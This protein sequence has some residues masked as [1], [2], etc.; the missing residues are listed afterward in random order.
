LDI[1]D[2]LTLLKR[3]Y[4]EVEAAPYGRALTDVIAEE[5]P[6]RWRLSEKYLPKSESNSVDLKQLQPPS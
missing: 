3:R 5:T 2:Q 1:D 4:A 6:R